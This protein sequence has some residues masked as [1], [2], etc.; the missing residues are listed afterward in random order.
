MISTC[1]G[2]GERGDIS[3]PGLNPASSA[4]PNTCPVTVPPQPG[5]VPPDVSLKML[6]LHAPEELG[7]S[8]NYI[9]Q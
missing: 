8:K 9:D 6:R 4:G 5:L 3:T 1:A 7:L 2:V